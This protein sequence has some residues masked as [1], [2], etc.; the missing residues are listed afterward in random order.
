MKFPFQEINFLFQFV[1]TPRKGKPR[2]SSNKIN[3]DTLLQR[4]QDFNKIK[5]SPSFINTQTLHWV[6]HILLDLNWDLIKT[7]LLLTCYTVQMT[8]T[9]VT[10]KE[11]GHPEKWRQR[12]HKAH[13]GDPEAW[14]TEATALWLWE[15]LCKWASS[16]S[17]EKRYTTFL[18]FINYPKP[19]QED[20]LLALKSAPNY[21]DLRE[22]HD[23]AENSPSTWERSCPFS[24]TTGPVF[25]FNYGQYLGLHK[26]EDSRY[27][28]AL[29]PK[30]F[31]DSTY[32]IL[33][34]D[35]VQPCAFHPPLAWS[36]TFK[37]GSSWQKQLAEDSTISLPW[38]LKVYF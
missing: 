22:L 3:Q 27:H 10:S 19:K 29:H 20:T 35:L 17:N 26:E 12:P 9:E 6:S 15:G 28:R 21:T 8:L 4:P 31:A 23:M 18:Y 7:N 11:I 24:S 1:V 33:G 34:E 2:S 36:K 30:P 38:N 14:R 16:T 13:R 25:I 5:S 37:S 32:H